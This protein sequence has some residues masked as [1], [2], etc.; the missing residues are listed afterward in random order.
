MAITQIEGSFPQDPITDPELRGR[1]HQ[2]VGVC[3]TTSLRCGL[4]TG[5]RDQLPDDANGRHH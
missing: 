1:V 5:K 2:K 4:D 3:P